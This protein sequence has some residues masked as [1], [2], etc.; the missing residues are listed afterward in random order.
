MRIRSI[1]VPLSVLTVAVGCGT[2][3]PSST[4]H[5]TAG[6]GPSDQVSTAPSAHVPAGAQPAAA[7]ATTVPS[8]STRQLSVRLG[9]GQGAAGSVYAPL[10]FTNTGRS[11]CRMTGYPGVSYVAPGSGHQVG[12]AAARNDQH[13][14]RTVTL[15]PGGHAAAVVQ[16]VNHFN[17]PRQRCRPAAV[18]GLRVYPPNNAAATYVAF[19]ADRTA[20]SSQVSQLTVQAVVGGT[21]GT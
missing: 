12:A 5:T 16:F 6:H 18:S 19:G 20:C 13:P 7:V 8:C 21:S 15:A 17:Y 4:G 14:A 3:S 9:S 2:S 1:L 11:S 10:V